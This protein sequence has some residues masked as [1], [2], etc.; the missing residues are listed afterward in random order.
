MIEPRLTHLFLKPEGVDVEAEIISLTNEMAEE[1]IHQAWWKEDCLKDRF[2]DPQPI[3]RY[4]NW[5]EIEI[6]PIFYERV[7]YTPLELSSQ[8]A[9]KLLAKWHSGG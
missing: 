8:N 4:W 7:S 6:D 9:Q 2:D 1:L 5:N 3:D